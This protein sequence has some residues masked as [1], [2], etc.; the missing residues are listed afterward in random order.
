MSLGHLL[1]LGAGG[2]GKV[3][4][5]AA[6]L[7]GWKSVSFLDDRWPTFSNL[8][9]WNVVGAF[10][11]L[12]K[13]VESFQGI[14]VAVG[15]NRLRSNL[16]IRLESLGAPITSIIHPSAIVARNVVIGQGSA[17][18][19]GAVINI[20]STVGRGV[21]VN[22]GASVDHD[23]VLG[24]FTHVCPG[25]RI[26]GGVHIE[27]CGWVGIGSSVIENICIGSE[28][29]IG[30]GAAVISDIPPNSTVVGIPA[31]VIKQD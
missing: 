25:A 21:I 1:I 20:G 4:A 19:A 5:D 6:L 24:D 28:V 14:F 31:R 15:S 17:C 11:D 10:Q 22:T 8:N 27:S 18:L 16:L 3:V 30:A 7:S 23:C 12:E 2:H 29:V 9:D 26:A 13:Y